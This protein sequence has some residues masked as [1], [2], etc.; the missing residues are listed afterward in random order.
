MYRIWY[1]LCY[2]D[3]VFGY[4]VYYKSYKR[5]GYAERIAD[6]IRQSSIVKK[7][8]V[9]KENPFIFMED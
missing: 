5:K 6:Q 2:E 3:A 7:V 9:A 8:I 4:S 1:E